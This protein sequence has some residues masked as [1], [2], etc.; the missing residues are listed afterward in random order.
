MSNL[1][2][3]LNMVVIKQP[4]MMGQ[5]A[6]TCLV[7]NFGWMAAELKGCFRNLDNAEAIFICFRDIVFEPPRDKTNILTCARSEDTNQL[8]HPPSLIRVFAVRS[9]GS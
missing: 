2:G 6:E 7:N 1:F 5:M 9:I 3:A 4:L 8:G